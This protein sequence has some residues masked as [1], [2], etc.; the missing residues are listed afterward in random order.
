MKAIKNNDDKILAFKLNW[1]VHKTTEG[2]INSIM[3]R[4]FYTKKN[5]VKHD[6][7]DEYMFILINHH[8]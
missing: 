1:M 6:Y 2:R 4:P 7:L 5:S 8:D 3:A